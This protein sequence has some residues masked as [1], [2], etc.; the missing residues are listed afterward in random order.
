MPRTLF[1]IALT[2]ATL[3]ATPA[4]AQT[5]ARRAAAM[6]SATLDELL[7]AD[8]TLRDVVFVDAQH[9]WAVGDRG[10]V[11]ATDDGGTH[12]YAQRSGVECPLLSV[13]FVDAQRGWI[14]G[15][16]ATPLTH[17]TEAVV[18]RTIDGGANWQRLPDPTLPRLVYVEF[19]DAAHGVAAGYGS[20]FYPSGLFTTQDGGKRWQPLVA[21]E[22]QTW[23]AADFIDPANG[24]LAGTRG[25]RAVVIDRE[26]HPAPLAS[27]DPR[28]PRAVAIAGANGGWMVGDDGLVLRTTDA[29]ATWQPPA[30][31]PLPLDGGQSRAWQ[32]STVAAVGEHVWLAGGPGNVV[33]HSADGG[34]SWQATATG[35]RTPLR[36][37]MF[38]DAQRG[39]AVG[40]LGAIVATEDGGRTWRRQRGGARLA[41]LAVVASPTQTPAETFAR[42]GAGE[43]YRTAMLPLFAADAR[44]TA[45]VDEQRTDEALSQLA[46]QSLRPLWSA[47]MPPVGYHTSAETLLEE[48]NR[49]T[50]GLAREQLAAKLVTTI[51]ALRPEVILVPHERESTRHAASALVEQLVLEAIASAADS[52]Q[53]LQ[54]AAVGLEPW[55]VKRVVGS[56]PDGERGAIRLPTDEFVAA[57]GGSPAG[58]CSAA[59]GLLFTEH[60]VP[61][62]LAEFETLQQQM[63]LPASTRDLFAGLK[64]APG[65][66][67]RR[68]VAVTNTADLDRLRKLTQKRRQLVR[69]LDYAEGSPMWSAQVVNLTGGLDS[70]SGGELVFQLAE[71]YRETGRHAMA[72]DTLYL[73]VR[74]YP[75]HPL[76]EQALT[77]L[78]RYYAS[79]EVAH[80]SSRE[81]A[82]N[83]RTRPLANV[84]YEND[85]AAAAKLLDES[86]GG[87][88]N[89]SADE[90]WERASALGKYLEQ[91]RPAV[92][93][94]PSIRFPLSVA[95]RKLG[96]ANTADR[97]FAILARSNVST[98]W[99]A[100]ARAENWLAKPEELPPQKPLVSCRATPAPPHL[101]GKFDEPF[102][103]QAEPLRIATTE[104]R[105]DASAA[106]V[107]LARD[108]EWLY[109]AI[110][111][112][113]LRDESYDSEEGPRAR[114]ADLSGQDRVHLA[115]DV[116][117]D[118]STAYQL[119]VDSRGWTHDALA[120]DASWDPRWFVA[121]QLS[122]TAW[123]AEIAIPWS[124]L[125]DPEPAVLDTW[126]LRAV[127]QNGRGHSASWTGTA[128][129]SPDSFGLLLFR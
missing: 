16:R 51:R 119:V 47:A 21:A 77:W 126:C 41:M 37:L 53:H 44:S 75:D 46:T 26:M 106:T 79:G 71:G 70:Q 123:M 109:V 59:R 66:D 89:L 94:E 83:T 73:L 68:P 8:A 54:L 122:E 112:T 3:F 18:L 111:C 12:W 19:F 114:D 52:T 64:L 22:Q 72:A 88:G 121:R 42:Y 124:E 63:G 67:A 4:W 117:R 116:D 60:T 103:Q 108:A 87:T 11:L 56:V 82:Q 17:R 93:A 92:Y 10:V 86:P 35:V 90:R 24:L 61:P 99:G 69:L 45:R 76:A 30:A 127:R 58:W 78:V 105:N 57:L 118:Y 40:D 115:I 49:Q 85:Q 107:Q 65:G 98:G 36:K 2:A 32:W 14:V 38:V 43:G 25:A 95:A 74:R 27:A 125:S 31:A 28:Q 102:W 23:L 97:Y 96:F 20:N 129:D 34:T 15:G 6:S 81:Q 128:G 101:D 1:A 84:P 48:L 5:S 104:G 33:V 120:G 39:F 7:A 13:S 113:R 9:G 50:D 100:A 110:T 91:A 29:G 62:S 80:A 55:Q